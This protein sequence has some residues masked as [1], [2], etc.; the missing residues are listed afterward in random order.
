MQPMLPIHFIICF[1]FNFA[2]LL[3]S[4]RAFLF[5]IPSDFLSSLLLSQYFLGKNCL[6]Q[7]IE[8]CSGWMG[9]GSH[10]AVPQHSGNDQ[11]KAE[12]SSLC[13]ATLPGELYE[14]QGMTARAHAMN[15]P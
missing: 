1:A 4:R 2:S 5:H 8:I 10:A 15:T 12:I 6:V 11:T 14:L 9:T 3:L 7:R 13:R